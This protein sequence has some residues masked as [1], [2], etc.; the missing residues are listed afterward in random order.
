MDD[1]YLARAVR[2]LRSLG[3]DQAD[4]APLAEWASDHSPSGVFGVVINSEGDIVG[5]TM[6]E[7]GPSG[8]R[9]LLS[10][11]TVGHFGLG[12]GISPGLVAVLVADALPGIDRS[13]GQKVA[14]VRSYDVH[15]GAAA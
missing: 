11:E 10:P 6:L 13:V 4:P 5:D 15:R 12:R 2:V 14:H 3:I 1:Y 7:R 8:D 9:W